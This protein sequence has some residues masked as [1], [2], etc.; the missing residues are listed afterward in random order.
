MS[1]AGGGYTHDCPGVELDDWPGLP[2]RPAWPRGSGTAVPVII[3][4]PSG[5]GS[6]A[7]SSKRLASSATAR[8][9]QRV[10]AL[11]EWDSGLQPRTDVAEHYAANWN[12]PHTARPGGE[13]LAQL[14]S[15]AVAAIT[16]LLA[17]HHDA[18]VMIGS[19]GTFIARTLVGLGIPVDWAFCQAMP[20]PAVYQI[21]FN[22]HQVRA[23]GPGLANTR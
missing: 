9:H 20:M 12:D 11:R 13:S 15:R 10:T 2:R 8:K 16:T 5:T 1:L 4:T 19:Y 17:R 22:A 23:A 3:C 6:D 21:R 7:G 14:S 18:A